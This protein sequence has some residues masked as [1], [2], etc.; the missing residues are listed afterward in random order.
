MCY[1]KSSVIQY[2]TNRQ[3][4]IDRVFNRSFE[5]PSLF[6]LDLIAPLEFKRCWK[7]MIPEIGQLSQSVY[8]MVLQH[9]SKL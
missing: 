3:R 4:P 6:P 8:Y 1:N 2:I 5:P 7:Q 9:I